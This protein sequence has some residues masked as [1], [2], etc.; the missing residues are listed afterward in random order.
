MLGL[1][2]A[3]SALAAP[4][5]LEPGASGALGSNGAE[6]GVSVPAAGTSEVESK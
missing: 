1:N 4:F 5:G 2:S 3:N 6:S